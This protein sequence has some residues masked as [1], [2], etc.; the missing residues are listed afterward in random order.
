MSYQPKLSSEAVEQS[1]AKRIEAYE[2]RLRD[3]AGAMYEALRYI[4][5]EESGWRFKRDPLEH[6]R[7]VI[8]EMRDKAREAIAL[9]D[10][11]TKC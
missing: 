4:A 3:A 9:V 2:K 5:D 6:A 8:D 10:G 7:S 1:R 11:N